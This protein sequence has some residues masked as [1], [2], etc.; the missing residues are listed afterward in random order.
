MEPQRPETMLRGF[1]AEGGMA[2]MLLVD[3][4]PQVEE[5]FSGSSGSCVCQQL[6][7]STLAELRNADM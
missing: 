2:S 7:S 4:G 5:N 6:R 3:F 1:A